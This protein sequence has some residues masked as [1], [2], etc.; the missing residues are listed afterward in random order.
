MPSD[1][2]ALGPRNAANAGRLLIRVAAGGVGSILIQL[3]RRLTSLTI[4]ATASRTETR[5][6]C[7]ELGAH[8]VIDHSRPLAPQLHEIGIPEVELI[9]S[10]NGTETSY[11]AV[12]EVLAPQG[13]F[14]V[15]DDAQGP[16]ASAL[17]RQSP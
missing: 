4:V 11:P 13:K 6:W 8:H 7:L 17:K 12:V 9:A 10:L 14:G 2:F 15:T 16:D 3:G 5:Q 1:R